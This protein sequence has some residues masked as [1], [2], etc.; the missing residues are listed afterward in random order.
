MKITMTIEV[1]IENWFSFEH[2]DERMWFEN[3]VL[4][5]DGT[6]I[7]HS[8]EVGDT[9]GVIKKVSNIKYDKD[10]KFYC[11]MSGKTDTKHSSSY[12]EC[13]FECDEC[14]LMRHNQPKN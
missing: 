2:D 8:N 1:D 3:E 7:L 10:I 6:L 13:F 5:G 11:A 12:S 9:V 4:I 14:R